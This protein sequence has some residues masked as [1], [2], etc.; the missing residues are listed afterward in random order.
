MRDL[1]H[2]VPPEAAKMLLTLFLSFLLGLEREEHK[3]AVD[4]YSFGGVRTFPLIGLIGYTMAFIS[5]NQLLPL[6]LGFAVVGGFS[7]VAYQHKL[8]TAEHAGVTTEMSGLAT[9]L[10]G[11]LVYRDQYWFAT[12]IT[13]L[14]LI[15]LELKD[16]LEGLNAPDCAG[17]DSYLHEVPFLLSAVILP[18]FPIRSSSHSRS[19]PSKHASS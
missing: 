8:T 11:A 10:V 17:R 12:A 5:G 3:V 13:V 4:H 16:V 7:M 1:V 6:T 18:I 2:L 14:S 15:L 19:I 9:Y